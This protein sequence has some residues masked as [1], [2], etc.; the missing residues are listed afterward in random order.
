MKRPRGSDA[1][2]GLVV[3]REA[4]VVSGGGGAPHQKTVAEGGRGTV[5]APL[6]IACALCDGASGV[7]CPAAAAL[8][9]LLASES[10]P[11]FPH[12]ASSASTLLSAKNSTPKSGGCVVAGTVVR[13][14]TCGPPIRNAYAS[15]AHLYGT[16]DISRSHGL[17]LVGAVLEGCGVEGGP[18][19][20]RATYHA[21]PPQQPT[22]EPEASGWVPVTWPL[23][24][25]REKKSG[26]AAANASVPVFG[27]V[28]HPLTAVASADSRSGDNGDTS[29]G[30][31]SFSVA[32]A[33]A[34]SA[35]AAA[36]L[37]RLASSAK[38]R[39][40]LLGVNGEAASPT[41]PPPPSTEG[42]PSSAAPRRVSGIVLE[43]TDQ[44]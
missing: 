10:A 18:A 32:T 3:L 25:S 5:C 11:A 20:G 40:V 16:A 15:E 37:L 23:P 34:L 44:L 21:C 6:H 12:V 43:Y 27:S 38:K 4:A 1:D 8:Q 17:G 22:A 19:G 36:Q 30:G 33:Q 24:T 2:D 29:N 7:Q 14:V 26:D 28:E 13:A 42:L 35:E 9:R 39:L 31:C 41:P